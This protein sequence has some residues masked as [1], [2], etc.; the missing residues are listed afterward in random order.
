MAF[1][2]S[3]SFVRDCNDGYGGV[4]PGEKMAV[5]RSQIDRDVTR[6]R[7]LPALKLDEKRG[8]RKRGECRP[9]MGCRCA[10]VGSVVGPTWVVRRS[11]SGF[12]RSM[13]QRRPQ[14]A[15]LPARIKV[16]RDARS[17]I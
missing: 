14:V 4:I 6:R 3:C 15:G 16:T 11:G 2:V 13:N 5:F 10:G 7:D 9:G 12:P 17:T 1:E 8:S